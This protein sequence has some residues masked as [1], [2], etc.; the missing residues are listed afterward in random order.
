M[1]DFISQVLR[2]PETA[3]RPEPPLA[4]VRTFVAADPVEVS[5]LIVTW[6]S[7]RWIERCLRSIPAACNGMRYE[8]VIQDNASTDATL[9]QLSTR[10]ATSVRVLESP[11]NAGFAAATNRA[12]HHSRGRYLFLLNPDCELEP[13][14]IVRLVRFLDAHPEVAAA[15]PLLIGEEGRPQS[16][17]QLRRFPTL[18][19]LASEI[20]L[21]DKI[22]PRNRAT[23]HYRYHDLDIT[24]PR[25]IEQPAAAAFVVRRD[26]F[27][28]IGPLDEQFWPAWFE[29]VDY[30]R[31]LAAA[32]EQV[33]I[34]PSARVRH[35]GG[36]SLRQLSFDRFTDLWYRNMWR[37]ANKWLSASEVEWLRWTIMG[38]MVLRS[39][40]AIGAPPSQAAGRVDAIRAYMKVLGKAFNRWDDSSPSSS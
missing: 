23:A 11:E 29:D 4:P 28:R 15:A 17:F 1:A 3:A 38:G 25:P 7:E 5:L 31:R 36:A 39:I 32:G 12:S 40:A 20:L 22:A 9:G 35:V 21:L 6:N 34:V 33:W 8:V 10:T 26:V 14:A 2:V 27:E 30:C 18:G 13:D 24:E 19:A 16:D 37:Y